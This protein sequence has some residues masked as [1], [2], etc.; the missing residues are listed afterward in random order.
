MTAIRLEL[1][2]VDR[3]E[4]AARAGQAR[5]HLERSGEVELGDARIQREDDVEGARS[6]SVP[7][8]SGLTRA[9]LRA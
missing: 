1:A 6:W 3:G 4:D 5:E 2:A 8:S 7:R 9:M